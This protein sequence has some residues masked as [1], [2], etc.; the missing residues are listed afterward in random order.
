MT[1][2]IP[3]APDDA[4]QRTGRWVAGHV[5]SLDEVIVEDWSNIRLERNLASKV[6]MLHEV[7]L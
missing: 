3:T 4:L 2:L 6:P 5:W 1:S 7:N